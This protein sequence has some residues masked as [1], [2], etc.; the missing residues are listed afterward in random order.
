MPVLRSDRWLN[1][2][3]QQLGLINTKLV[4]L[5]QYESTNL[6]GSW[7]SALWQQNE[8]CQRMASSSYGHLNRYKHEFIVEEMLEMKPAE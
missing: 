8:G 2:A 1:E 6:N 5:K 3:S 4:I 7:L